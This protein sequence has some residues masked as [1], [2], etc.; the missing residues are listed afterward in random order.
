MSSLIVTYPHLP[1][2]G[3]PDRLNARQVWAVAQAVR[4]QLT[5][6]PWQRR[7]EVDLIVAKTEALAVNEVAFGAHWDLDHDVRNERG[8][9]VMGMADFDPAE[10]DSIYVSINGVALAGRDDLLRS[11][12]AHELGHVVFDGP[13]WIR[14]ANASCTASFDARAPAPD[15]SDPSTLAG[16]RGDALRDWREFRANEFMGA[17]LAPLPLLRLDL[18]R[19]AKRHRIPRSAMGSRVSRGSPAYDASAF[20]EDALIEL[21]FALA[22]RYGVSE[23]FIRVRLERYDLLRTR[24]FSHVE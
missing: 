3:E 6:D 9:R 21:L 22:E 7:M 10:P 14:R 12:S 2:F 19:F 8:R 5:D 23:P 17:L 18:Q 15:N 1:L 11:T 16:P 4:K 24:S 20:A 13:G